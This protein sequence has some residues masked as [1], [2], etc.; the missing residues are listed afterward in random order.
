LLLL[1]AL[2]GLGVG[3]FSTTSGMILKSRRLV[4]GL[5]LSET[6]LLAREVLR[7]TTAEE[8]KKALDFFA[9]CH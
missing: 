8:V 3:S 1:P 4:A 2:L 9:K 6:T 5:T 7:C